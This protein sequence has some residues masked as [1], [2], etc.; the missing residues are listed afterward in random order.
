MSYVLAKSFITFNY[1]FEFTEIKGLSN[2]FLEI[3][4]LNHHRILAQIC[5]RA[6]ENTCL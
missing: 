6:I 4:K 2:I 3:N 1:L 5:P